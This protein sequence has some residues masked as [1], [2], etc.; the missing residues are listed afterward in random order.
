M[1]VDAL[2]KGGI[3]VAE[4]TLTVPGA[5]KLIE[6]LRKS[7]GAELLVGAGTVV[8]VEGAQRCLD[9]GAQFIISPG[10]DAAT[11]E[12]VKSQEIVMI[13]AALTP[14][15][16]MA[17]W[18][19][20]ADLIKVFP[21]N[22]VGGPTYIKSLKGPFPEIPLI[23]TGGV[24]LET[25]ADFI[26]AGSAALGVGSELVPASALGSGKPAVITELAM[27]F[28]EIVREARGLKAT[29]SAVM[30]G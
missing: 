4:I 13:A 20:G 1:A 8:D 6:S 25:A 18:K 10:F 22:A 24:N 14:T 15:E 16:I 23:P 29:A 12:F 30:G 2:Y 9:A 7:F 21:C 3:S 17:A 26:S 27:Q 5:E 11:V 19:N 28:L